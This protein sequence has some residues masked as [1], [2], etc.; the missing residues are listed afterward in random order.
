VW[1]SLKPWMDKLLMIFLIILFLGTAVYGYRYKEPDLASSTID[2]LKQVL[3]AYLILT[4]AHRLPFAGQ[5]GGSNG[6]TTDGSTASST[7][8]GT[9]SVRG[10]T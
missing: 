2:L 4:N 6:K 9:P 1:E 10:T 7:V 5:N 3:A 8:P